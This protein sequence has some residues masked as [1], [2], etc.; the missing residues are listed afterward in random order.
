MRLRERK[1]ERA[2]TNWTPLCGDI[3]FQESLTTAR[4]WRKR[5]RKSRIADR[6]HLCRQH[7][8]VAPKNP[9]RKVVHFLNAKRMASEKERLSLLFAGASRGAGA[10]KTRMTTHW[11]TRPRSTKRAHTQHPTSLA[12]WVGFCCKLVT[13]DYSLE[14]KDRC[15]LV[16][17]SDHQMATNT[18]PRMSSLQSTTA[19]RPVT[20]SDVALHVVEQ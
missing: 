19:R 10:R 11:T 5:G 4:L 3:E 12:G 20:S 2:N 17:L 7:S 1:R 14:A 9:T 16:T 13:F 15:D 8:F 18:C 6:M